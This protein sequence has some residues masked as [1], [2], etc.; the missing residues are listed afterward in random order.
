MQ[1]YE[2]VL[3]R[4]ESL[5]VAAWIWRVAVVLVMAVVGAWI[6]YAF[7]ASQPRIIYS[8]S[9]PHGDRARFYQLL[10]PMTRSFR[11]KPAR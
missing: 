7:F 11:S 6:W 3:G 5:Q 1:N 8:E 4:T 10:A 9:L 2:V